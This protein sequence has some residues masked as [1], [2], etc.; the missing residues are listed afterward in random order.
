MG[1]TIKPKN[2]KVTRFEDLKCWQAAR[3]VVKEIFVVC[4]SGPLAV[5]FDTKSQLRRAALSMMNNIAEGFGRFSQ[6]EFIRFLDFSKSS[7]LE[8]ESMLYVLE[9]LEYISND[10]LELL[11]TKTKDA[12]ALTLAMIRYL[13]TRS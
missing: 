5:D 7:A 12:K 10:K 1:L 2:M 8:V 3:I 6:K 9:D 13:N 4:K 11:R